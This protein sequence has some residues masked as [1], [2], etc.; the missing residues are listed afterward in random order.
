MSSV[1]ITGMIGIGAFFGVRASSKWKDAKTH[2]TASYECDQSGVDLTDEARSS[3]NIATLG[4]IAGT[5]LLAAGVVLFVTAPSGAP[6]N[7]VQVGVGP[8]SLQ[9]RGSF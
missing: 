6:S 4:F 2:C 8:G 7:K 3:G 5:A 9:L 1:T